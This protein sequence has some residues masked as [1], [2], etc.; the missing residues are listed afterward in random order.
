M[1]I[2]AIL[3]A[4]TETLQPSDIQW[5][6][7]LYNG[8]VPGGLWAVPRS[9]LIFEKVEDGLVL[10]EVMPWMPEMGGVITPEELVEQQRGEF[11]V[12]REHF[13]AA[14]ITVT[15]DEGVLDAG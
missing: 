3:I 9:G 7:A 12:I 5:C 14:D 15:K 13:A 10:H 8:L 2:A 1:P 11:E 6:R 4:M